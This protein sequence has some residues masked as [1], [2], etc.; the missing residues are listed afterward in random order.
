MKTAAGALRSR[1]AVVG[2]GI[3]VCVAGVRAH[4]GP[5]YPIVSKRVVGPYLA[6]IWTDPDATDDRSAAGKF[7]VTLA[8][9]APREALPSETRATVSIVPTD[10]AGEVVSG[11]TRPVNRDPSNQFVALVMDHEGPYAVRV[12][13]RGPL[14][15]AELESKVDAT[16]DLRPQPIML[17][18]YLVPFVLV[19]ALWG[20]LL[21][22]RAAARR[23]LDRMRNLKGKR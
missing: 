18:V 1:L 10:R 15:S 3:A 11:A 7:W 22:K 2:V 5:P 14:G 17:L 19:A 23:P 12:T 20:K 13:I 6:S 4:S 16:Y 9:A 8:A 21:F